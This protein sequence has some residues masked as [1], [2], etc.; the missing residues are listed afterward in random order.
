MNLSPTSTHSALALR[1][2]P[3]SAPRRMRVAQ[4]FASIAT[5]LESRRRRRSMRALLELDDRTLADIGLTRARLI[6]Q[7]HRSGWRFAVAPTALQILHR[8]GEGR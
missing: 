3:G 4:L 6:A 2:S 5:L 1:S 7:A 8:A